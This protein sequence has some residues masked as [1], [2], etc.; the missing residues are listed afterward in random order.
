MGVCGGEM[1][2]TFHP[3]GR[4]SRQGL[5]LEGAGSAT[6]KEVRGDRRAL[7]RFQKPPRNPVA[8]RSLKSLEKYPNPWAEGTLEFWLEEVARS[9][10]ARV[11][12]RPTDR[13]EA[14]EVGAGLEGRAD[15]VRVTAPTF[16][17]V[18][19]LSLQGSPAS[20]DMI[21][22]PPVLPGAPSV[23]RARLGHAYTALPHSARQGCACAGVWGVSV[24]Q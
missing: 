7:G 22:L 3:R 21:H 16:P 10:R 17:Q 5:G 24:S 11:T 14:S 19:Q 9:A 13:P 12:N 20:P 15:S 18:P 6:L 1:Q 8:G 4:G 23:Q 2:G